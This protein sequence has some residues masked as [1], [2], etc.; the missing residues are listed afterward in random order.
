MS[1]CT[2]NGRAICACLLIYFFSKGLVMEDSVLPSPHPPLHHV[3]QY[4]TC[5]LMYAVCCHEQNSSEMSEW[6]N[7]VV[8]LSPE[9]F[10]AWIKTRP[11]DH[12]ST[13][14]KD[15][16]AAVPHLSTSGSRC[17]VNQSKAPSVFFAPVQIKTSL[18]SDASA[19]L[20]ASSCFL[21]ASASVLFSQSVPVHTEPSGPRS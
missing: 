19:R 18:P 11:A 13:I 4:M 8:I 3:I 9:K 1:V 21:V 14:L 20:S 17:L 7:D 15:P 2:I 5:G 10:N 6:M 12:K 16:R